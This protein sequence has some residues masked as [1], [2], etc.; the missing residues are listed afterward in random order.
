MAPLYST[1]STLKNDKL[2]YGI[3]KLEVIV[4]PADPLRKAFFMITGSKYDNI[5]LNPI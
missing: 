4:L 5:Q 1:L 2:I 3:F